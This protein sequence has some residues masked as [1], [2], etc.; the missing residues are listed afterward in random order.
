VRAGEVAGVELR[1]LTPGSSPQLDVCDD[2]AQLVV[3]DQ[4]EEIFTLCDDARRRQALIDGL[5]ALHC[6]V[7]I[8]VPEQHA[9]GQAIAN[10]TARITPLCH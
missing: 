8:G 1:L 6:Q 3:V 10:S 9:H 2:A 4:F 5:L 7:A